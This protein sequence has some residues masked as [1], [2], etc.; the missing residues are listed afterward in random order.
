[1]NP[2]NV[3]GATATEGTPIDKTAD[4][5]DHSVASATP[6]LQA[7]DEKESSSAKP[8]ADIVVTAPSKVPQSPSSTRDGRE[9]ES[10]SE[11][12]TGGGSISKV[13]ANRRVDV[14]TSL[15]NGISS[16][17]SGLTHSNLSKVSLHGT[18][19]SILREL[20]MEEE[21][22]S[23]KVR[24]LYDSRINAIEAQSLLGSVPSGSIRAGLEKNRLS[25]ISAASNRSSNAHTGLSSARN[26][27]ADSTASL[28][29]ENSPQENDIKLEF[30]YA[31][32]A[33]DWEDVDADDIDRYGFITPKPRTSPNVSRTSIS[34]KPGHKRIS[35]ALS[36]KNSSRKH[37]RLGSVRNRHLNVF[38]APF[39]SKSSPDILTS[40]IA[41][42]TE[43]M[44]AK[45]VK[46]IAKW[47]SM[48][49]A[50]DRVSGSA[51]NGGGMNFEFQTSDPKNE[52]GREYL[53]VGDLLLG[54]HSWNQALRGTLIVNRS[55][56]SL[57][58]T[59][60]NL[61]DQNSPDDVQIDL[62]VPRTISSHIMFRRRYR[63]G[64][65]LLFRVLHA[66]S[67]YFPDIGYVQGMASLAATF[68]CY[69][70]EDAA[71]VMMV[72]LFELRGMHRL[73]SNG[74]SGLM[75]ALN[76]FDKEWLQP[77][78][79]GVKKHLDELCISALSFGTRWYLTLF[80][81]SIPF[82]MQLRVWDVFLLL[83]DEDSS[84]SSVSLG[85]FRG[86]LDPLHATSV[87]LI[88]GMGGLVNSDFEAAMKSL[89]NWIPLKD[90]DRLMNG[91]RLEW[92]KRKRRKLVDR[93]P[94][95]LLAGVS[96][97]GTSASRLE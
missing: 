64:Q 11:R 81:Y 52:L 76:E 93:F 54:F 55:R 86:T 42:S 10:S 26:S 56:T 41:G 3:S 73:Y 94:R 84:A 47:Q 12:Q 22:M 50:V 87:A 15:G 39:N 78:Y 5:V 40:P 24:S 80:N 90:E 79:P 6:C 70:D 58:A 71:F 57:N 43:R 30:E 1:M 61:L 13:N 66:V 59:M 18:G 46:R 60:S 19:R 95:A 68:L 88:A 53:T 23:L 67:L 25:V 62:D 91:A 49:N 20:T 21:F 44:K 37:I 89:T 85:G 51:T 9:D 75:D 17:T 82:A 29:L 96:R 65:R 77:S 28:N 97:P 83:G 31:G 7:W 74:F 35:A 8:S 69:Y 36:L 32:G 4:S 34:N 92:K 27:T 38:M 72:R 14:A 48:A 63:G 33:E 16:Q 2:E 45:E